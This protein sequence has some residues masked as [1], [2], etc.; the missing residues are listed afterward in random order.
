MVL[1]KEL[2]TFLDGHSPN[3]ITQVSVEHISQY[4]IFIEMKQAFCV[5][6]VSVAEK[7][8]WQSIGFGMVNGWPIHF[9][10]LFEYTKFTTCCLFNRISFNRICK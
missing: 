5:N 8:I 7:A 1:R 6:E 2:G 4:A 3:V 10:K 9:H